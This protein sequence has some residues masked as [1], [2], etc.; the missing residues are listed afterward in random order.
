[1]LALA[2]CAGEVPPSAR[3]TALVPTTMSPQNCLDF[4]AQVTVEGQPRHAVGQT[5]P[6][7]DGSWRVTLRTPGL[8][9]QIYTLPPQAIYPHPYPEPS[10]WWNPWFYGPLYAVGPVFLAHPVHHHHKFHHKGGSRH[11][12]SH[13]GG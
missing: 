7:P 10:Y 2:G 3:D 1:M 13:R 8:Q 4:I 12:G 5:C 11:G 9:E 6:Q